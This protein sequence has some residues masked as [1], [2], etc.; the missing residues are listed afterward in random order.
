MK[1]KILQVELTI[2]HKIAYMTN[3]YFTYGHKNDLNDQK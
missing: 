3:K 1:Y 2:H